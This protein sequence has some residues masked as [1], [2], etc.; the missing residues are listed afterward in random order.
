MQTNDD[1]SRSI[2]RLEGRLDAQDRLL[3]EIRSEM[4]TVSE[5]INRAKGS[6]QLLM[7]LG[8]MASA[9]GAAIAELIHWI[10]GA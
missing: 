8:G 7:V 5:Y 6:W 2:G 4:H 9:F 3:V 10:K 1:L